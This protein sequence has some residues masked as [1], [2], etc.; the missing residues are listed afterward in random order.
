MPPSDIT[1]RTS[2]KIRLNSLRYGPERT[3]EYPWERD[4]RLTRRGH[5][6]PFE[7]KA[8]ERD[9]ENNLCVTGVELYLDRASEEHHTD[10]FI[11]RQE[12]SNEPDL[13]VRRGKPFLVAVSLNETFNRGKHDLQ[14]SFSTGSD[15]PNPADGTWVL[16]D[17]KDEYDRLRKKHGWRMYV[18]RSSNKSMVLEVTT[19]PN[20][21][22]GEWVLSIF[23]TTLGI[24][25]PAKRE[26]RYEY[27][28]DIIILFNPW[29][30]ADQVYIDRV[31]CPEAGVRGRTEPIDEYGLNDCG[32]VFM[33][34]E[35]KIVAKPWNYGQFDED[36][37]KISLHLLRKAFN[38]EVTSQLSD[39]VLVSRG[40]TKV[41]NNI[42][43]SGVMTGRYR[44]T[45]ADGVR[46][47]A[48]VGSP[49]ILK[50]YNEQNG[51]PVKYGQPWVFS[52]VY[53]TV[54]RALGLPCR[55]VT[56]FVS[57]HDP[58]RNLSI[59]KGYTIDPFNGVEKVVDTHALWD[60]HVWNEVWMKRPDLPEKPDKLSGWQVLDPTPQEP[61]GHIYVCGPTP[62]T[63]VRKGLCD[64]AFDTAFVFSEVNAGRT[65]WQRR[66]GVNWVKIKENSNISGKKISTKYPDGR[67]YTGEDTEANRYDLT[68]FYKYP[69]DSEESEIVMRNALRSMKVQRQSETAEVA[70]Q[71]IVLDIVS[72]RSEMVGSDVYFT[73]KVTN[74]SR[75]YEE[76]TIG[77]LV[78][79][80]TTHVYTGGDV[81]PLKKVV[82][83]SLHLKYRQVLSYQ[84]RVSPADYDLGLKPL[85]IFE[86]EATANV[87]ETGNIAVAALDYSLT[88]P[89]VV[90]Q[91]Q[92]H[93]KVDE[94]TDVHLILRNP[95]HD[96][97][98]TFCVVS[99]EGNLF[100]TPPPIPQPNV[101]PH[102]RW[103]MTVPVTAKKSGTGTIF[104]SFECK[105]IPGIQG[106]TK[107]QVYD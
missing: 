59:D 2:P 65:I 88:P 25:V 22:I 17:V 107:L 73:I 13:I 76:L 87:K 18:I 90:I 26:L 46:P 51:L 30:P 35:D 86:V 58:D 64:I 75:E 55:S 56:N 92:S 68:E 82:Y 47:T 83:S 42:D 34:R 66:A 6:R 7:D 57:A 95:F 106:V 98:L 102:G 19:P 96:T 63:A 79:T 104:V 53:T 94:P 77:N 39:P 8:R 29:N 11:L 24:Y 60:F 21:T 15:R 1:P 61:S 105:E 91:T 33:G 50:M 69:E 93:C 101:K 28:G 54:C 3:K 12:S 80:V 41:I 70:K 23:S 89:T 81:T 100:G 4:L 103:H 5:P 36:V 37:L 14:L 40:L 27:P 99:I 38:F 74:I 67:P 85:L 49:R 78:I 16:L 48:W 44:G 9:L 43:G 10:R 45:F 97:W 32:I 20:C 31:L 71:D 84:L 72:E 52:G 62:V